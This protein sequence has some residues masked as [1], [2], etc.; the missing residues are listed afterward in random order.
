MGWRRCGYPERACPVGESG[1]LFGA[2]PVVGAN[3]AAVDL[4]APGLKTDGTLP[5][6][7]CGEI[8]GMAFAPCFGLINAAAAL[9]EFK[10][11]E[12]VC[13][14]GHKAEGVAGLAG[15]GTQG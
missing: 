5:D 2:E 4:D 3:H 7:I 10:L 8:D 1:V 13:T 15:G 6:K 14:V 9:P 11:H 12:V